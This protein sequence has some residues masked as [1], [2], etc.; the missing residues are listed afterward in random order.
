MTYLAF[1]STPNGY[2]LREEEGEPPH[3]GEEVE[4][5]GRR[6]QVLKVAQSPL[7]ND[8]RACVYLQG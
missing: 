5:D 8:Q 7:P 6:W 4:R 1:T 2:E 3:V